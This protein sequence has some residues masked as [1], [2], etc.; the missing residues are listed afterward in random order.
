MYLSIWLLWFYIHSKLGIINIRYIL[1]TQ[2]L[3]IISIISCFDIFFFLGGILSLH[4]ICYYFN[5]RTPYDR[6]LGVVF[7]LPFARELSMWILP[8][9]MGSITC[10]QTVRGNH[11]KIVII[12]Q[13]CK[14]SI[15]QLLI[16]RFDQSHWYLYILLII[17]W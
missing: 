10:L 3:N 4:H 6:S 9:F 1:D 14:C 11:R 12:V 2:H 16:S 17:Y 8:Y 15:L 7:Y 13:K 5:S